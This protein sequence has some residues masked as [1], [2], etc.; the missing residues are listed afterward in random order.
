MSQSGAYSTQGVPARNGYLLCQKHVNENGGILGRKIEFLIFD[1]KSDDKTAPSLYEKLIVEDKIDAVM[2]PYGSPLTEAVAPE[3]EK[4]RKVM[5]TPLAATTTIWEQ[6]RRYIFMQLAPSELFLAELIDIGARNGLK[7]VALITE[8]TIF[9]KSA[10]KGT[11]DFAKNTRSTQR[12][13]KTSR[14]S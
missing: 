5:L 12:V 11:M 9:P 10:A 6:G 3:T 1:D 2:G 14:P 8:D 4:H 13:T 7:T